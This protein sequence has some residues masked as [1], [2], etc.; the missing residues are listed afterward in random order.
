MKKKSKLLKIATFFMLFATALVPRPISACGFQEEFQV[1]H[2][3][4]AQ[5]VIAGRVKDYQ[6]TN[7]HAILTIVADRSMAGKRY[8]TDS[9]LDNSDELKASWKNSTFQLPEMMSNDRQIFALRRIAAAGPPLRG[10][11]G[12]VYPD[13]NG[14][15]F[16]IL[17]APCTPAFILPYSTMGWDNIQEI[18]DGGSPPKFLYRNPDFGYMSRVYEL[19]LFLK[20]IASLALLLLLTNALILRKYRNMRKRMRSESKN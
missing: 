12:V 8:I 5:A 11:S 2:V 9:P 13:T 19:E 17:Q 10:A 18:L 7:G 4:F 14:L 3:K 20:A 15:D 16:T 1:D 6:I